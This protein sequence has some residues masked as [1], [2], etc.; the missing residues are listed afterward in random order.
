LRELQGA[1][2][3]IIE[4][5]MGIYHPRI[6]YPERGERVLPSSADDV[7]PDAAVEDPEPDEAPR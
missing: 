5:L 3:T 6:A 4:S 7:Y 2:N 1:R